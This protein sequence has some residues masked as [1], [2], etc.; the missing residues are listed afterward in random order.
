MVLQL[1][2]YHPLSHLLPSTSIRKHGVGGI[3][4]CCCYNFI[5]DYHC[6]YIDFI[7]LSNFKHVLENEFFQFSL[8]IKC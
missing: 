8:Q 3:K 1:G 7:R 6:Q 5:N 2:N 4:F